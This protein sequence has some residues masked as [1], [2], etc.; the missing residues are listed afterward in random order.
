MMRM[1]NS[2]QNLQHGVNEN[3][4]KLDHILDFL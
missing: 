3:N 4:K 2:M 1:E